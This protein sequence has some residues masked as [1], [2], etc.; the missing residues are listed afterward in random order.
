M[1]DSLGITN[2]TEN[3][4]INGSNW[5]GCD[6]RRNNESRTMDEMR[7]TVEGISQIEPERRSLGKI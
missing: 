6:E 5:F 2:V 4:I 7:N 1:R 3:P